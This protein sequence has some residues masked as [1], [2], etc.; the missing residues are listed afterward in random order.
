MQQHFV[1]RVKRRFFRLC[2]FLPRSTLCF[3]YLDGGR[4][5]ATGLP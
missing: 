3:R 2:F 4:G 1:V 5:Q